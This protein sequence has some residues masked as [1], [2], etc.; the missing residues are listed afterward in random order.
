MT[1]LTSPAWQ[2]LVGQSDAVHTLQRAVEESRLK[3]PGTAMSHA[4]L[5]TGPPGAGRSTAA[6]LFA[7]ALECDAGGCAAES[8]YACASC[9]EV[10]HDTH[11]DV[12]RFN[13]Q[14]LQITVDE[15]RGLISRA[16]LTP[17]RGAWTVMIVEDADRL[18]EVSGNML[19]K[20][21]EEPTPHTVWLLCA[22]ST[23]DVLPT[24]RSRCRVLALRTPPWRDVAALLEADGVDS[25]MAS[26]AAR[27]AQGHVGRARALAVDEQA[28]L[29]RQQVLR[30]PLQLQSLPACFAAAAD[31]VATATED[32][33]AYT[34]PL[35][36]VEHDELLRAYGE[37]ASGQGITKSRID[38]LAKGAVKEL[39]AHQ[40]SRR[41]RAVRDRLDRALVDLLTFYRD[42]LVVQIGSQ[43]DLVNEEL[44]PSLVRVAA[45][46]SP[47]SIRRR[48]DA[49]TR[50]RRLLDS[51]ASPQ[52]L[53]EG[54]TVELA[55]G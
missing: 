18:N 36:S 34:E 27:A 22:P 31:I 15:A 1:D 20:A 4:W 25:S 14:Q 43:V 12:V 2:S 13:P 26:F 5:L 17:D 6:L 51:N 50:T 49:I 21:I 8:S 35:D 11:P 40:K 48:L 37:G 3:P 10:H 55:R 19:L 53:L 47:E 38:K 52:L 41:T 42:V 46:S 45:E 9:R 24:I 7:A 16:G 30:I 54:L 32:A 39:E 28:R 33:T 29:R 44:R 23:E